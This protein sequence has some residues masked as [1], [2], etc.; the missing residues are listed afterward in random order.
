MTDPHT[1]ADELRDEIA[2]TRE[3]LGDT[4]EQLAQ[5]ADV[6]GPAH[7]KVDQTQA[8]IEENKVPIAGIAAAI[9]GLVLLLWLLR[10]R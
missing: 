7:A 2:E 6:K 8:K 3:G 1:E 4:V 9:G 5:K 10:R